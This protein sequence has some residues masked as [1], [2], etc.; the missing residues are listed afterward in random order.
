MSTLSGFTQLT[1]TTAADNTGRSTAFGDING[2]GYDDLVI[3]AFRQLGDAPGKVYIVYGQA[4]ALSSELLSASGVVTLTGASNG[5][6]TGIAVAVGDLNGDGFDD[7]AIGSNKDDSSSTDAGAVYVIYG[8]TAAISS[9]TL[10]ASVGARLTGEVAG[11]S[12]GISLAIVDVNADGFKDL[13]I[14]ATKND[15]AGSNAGAVYV[16]PGSATSLSGSSSLGP[17]REYS[18]KA[19]GDQLGGSVAGGDIDGNGTNDIIAGAPI[20]GDGGVGAG[21]AFVVYMTSA[22][23]LNGTTVS[24]AAAAELGGEAAGDAAGTNVAAGDVNGDGYDD[25]LVSAI[26]NGSSGVSAGSVHVI[27]GKS[28]Q[29][30]TTVT[31]VVAS[32]TTEY[33]GETGGDGAGYGL[34]SADLNND[35]YAEILIG[36]I[37][38]N[39]STGATYIVNGAATLTGGN[40]TTAANTEYDGLDTSDS[41]GRWISTGDFN[42]DGFPEIAISAPPYLSGAGTGAVYLGYLSID[43]DSDG[44]LGTA[45]ILYTGTDCSDS[46]ATVYVNQTF[47]GDIDGD[48]LGDPAVTTSVC[49]STAPTGYT[50]NANDTNDGISNFGVEIKG[51]DIDNN[52]NGETDEV[53]TGSHPYY[54]TLSA[55]DSTSASTD[56]T[57]VKGTTDGT[58]LVTYADNSVFAYQVFSVTSSKDTQVSQYK[59]KAYAVAM[60]PKGKQLKLVNLY[61]G[62]TAKSLS[63]TDK[64]QTG[65]KLILNDFRSDGKLEAAVINQLKDTVKV[66]LL[67]ISLKSEK[68]QKK[69]QLILT[70]A[71][72]VNVNKT[73]TS[74]NAIKLRNDKG[75]ILFTIGVDKTYQ[76]AVQS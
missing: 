18:G 67:G 2:D 25:V 61:T 9:Q 60:H 34:A 48:T 15:D 42:G 30:T 7:V 3:G 26:T 51:D 69:D 40:L 66:S 72:Q 53:N 13:I 47:Y 33:D 5:D 17:T 41:A 76:L 1:G 75:E 64:N 4:A 65:A 36:S 29:Y 28:T 68:F 44:V 37:A 16:T 70:G 19:A 39:T 62:E 49:S 54:S 35:G 10:S 38:N 8:K 21:A 57:A 58:I 46:D 73:K 20:N 50:D 32:G 74:K 23:T 22:D 14:G 45:G 52:E 12:A 43:A 63:L 71:K 59:H 6:Q 55:A 56:I 31:S 24:I 11:D 27:P